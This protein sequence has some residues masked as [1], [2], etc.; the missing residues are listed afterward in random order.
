MAQ[1]LKSLT[2]INMNKFELHLDSLT[3]KLV[4]LQIEVIIICI[5]DL[6]NY[7]I[8]FVTANSEIMNDLSIKSLRIAVSREER[9]KKRD[10]DK[11]S[12]K[13][14]FYIIRRI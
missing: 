5:R 10:K 4:M 11:I 6:I 7:P 14:I 2:K 13:N 1:R 8:D 12:F 9:M 3:D